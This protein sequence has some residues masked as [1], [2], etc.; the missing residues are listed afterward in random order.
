MIEL[1]F[2]I[3]HRVILPL[4]YVLYNQV[5]HLQYLLKNHSGIQVN[6]SL[7]G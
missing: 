3:Y 2:A 1:K 4:I 6:P 7:D 5:I